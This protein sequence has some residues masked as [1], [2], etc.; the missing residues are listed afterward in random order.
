MCN[1]RKSP[2]S[3]DAENFWGSN[4]GTG[5]DVSAPGVKI[6]TTD[7]SG[8]AGYSTGNYTASFNGTSSATP[9]TAGVVALIL[10]VNPGLTYAQARQILESSCEK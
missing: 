3:C 4:F 7:I 9:N 10:S 1:Q 6:Y 8:T 2:T 5:V